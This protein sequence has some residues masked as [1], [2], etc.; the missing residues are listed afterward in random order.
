[1]STDLLDKFENEFAGDLEENLSQIPG[2]TISADE[3]IELAD[4]NIL[5]FYID[6]GDGELICSSSFIPNRHLRELIQT[7]NIFDIDF[8]KKTLKYIPEDNIVVLSQTIN[9]DHV[10]D[11]IK[12]YADRSIITK[13]ED[14][15][16][17]ALGIEI[18]DVLN[19]FGGSFVA[20]ISSMTTK[21]GEPFP[22]FS[23]VFDMRDNKLLDKMMRQFGSV[24]GIKKTSTYY[25]FPADGVDFFMD[26]NNNA[27]IVTND[28]K[29]I[30][31]F[32]KGGY[33]NHFSSNKITKNISYA[34]LN[35]DYNKYSDLIEESSGGSMPKEAEMM[36]DIW[37]ELFESVEVK[38]SIGKSSGIFS[39]E[40]KLS[41][42]DKNQNILQTAY[43][44]VEKEEVQELLYEMTAQSGSS[45]DDDEYYDDYYD[46]DG[47]YDEDDYYDED[48][49]Y[50]ADYYRGVI[51]DPDGYTNVR[52][53]KSSRSEIVFK[54]YEGE[55]F[56]IID[57]KDDNWWL[58]Q[59]NGDQG[60][61]YRDRINVVK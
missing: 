34:Y 26:F 37:K 12:K 55:E 58:I 44:L 54:V 40:F 38:Q 5:T 30:R 31:Q 52:E 53:D 4:N 10:Y 3:I 23:F 50:D 46:E 45:A 16:D 36:M 27:F 47:Y 2:M 35:L 21:R 1:M 57:D 59:Y 39:A 22:L 56:E 49:Y 51:N 13:F 20:N 43:E 32:D 19:T 61:I 18:D 14:G 6:F 48:E 41:F 9:V 60:Y 42:K 33:S 15:M 28:K 24:A 11:L 29:S 25:T 8:N 7:Y 17:E